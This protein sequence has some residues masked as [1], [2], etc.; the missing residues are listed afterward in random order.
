MI[1]KYGKRIAKTP[2]DTL[3]FSPN[4]STFKK[5]TYLCQCLAEEHPLRGR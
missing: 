4:T 5:I 3:F 2:S 1:E